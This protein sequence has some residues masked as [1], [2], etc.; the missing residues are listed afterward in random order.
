M[1]LRLRTAALAWLL[2]GPLGPA[3]LPATVSHGF[4]VPDGFE[5]SVFAGDDLAHDIFCMTTDQAGR[6]VVASKGG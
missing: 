5:V 2:A 4:R 3:L 6:I 1:S